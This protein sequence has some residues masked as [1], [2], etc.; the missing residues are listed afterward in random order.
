M[1]IWVF[2]FTCIK[3]IAGYD[4]TL[5]Q[6]KGLLSAYIFILLRNIINNWKIRQ[7]NRINPTIWC[8]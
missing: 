4:K 2:H 3:A 7:Q 5:I 6:E 8:I 1:F